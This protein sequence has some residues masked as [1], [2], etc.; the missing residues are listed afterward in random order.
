MSD[1]CVFALVLVLA[2]PAAGSGELRDPTR[3]PLI[4][5]GLEGSSASART[6]SGVSSILVAPERRVAIIGGRSVGTG[7][8][9]LGGQVLEILPHSVRVRTGQGEVKL[10][11]R[12]PPVKQPARG[13]EGQDP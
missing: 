2:L 11:L 9:T 12:G 13:G 4:G 6:A 8:L 3:P 7:D 1:R 10:D 5:Q